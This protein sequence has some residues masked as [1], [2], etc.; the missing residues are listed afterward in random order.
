MKK[1]LLLSVMAMSF[2]SANVDKSI[3]KVD[4]ITAHAIYL[5]KKSAKRA[6]RIYTQAQESKQKPKPKHRLSYLTSKLKSFESLCPNL[7]NKLEP[8]EQLEFVA[9][10]NAYSK[11]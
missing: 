1:I 9:F 4:A 10:L 7:K 2:L 8:D 3:K 5:Q 6:V 11:L